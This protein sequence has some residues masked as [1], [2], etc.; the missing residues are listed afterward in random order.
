M[1][2]EPTTDLAA[3]PVVFRAEFNN[4]QII[5]AAQ[6]VSL[7]FTGGKD[8]TVAVLRLIRGWLRF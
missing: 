6:A 4:F 7:L 8:D 2:T 5:N 1:T 3:E